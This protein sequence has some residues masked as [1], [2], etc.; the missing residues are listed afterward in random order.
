MEFE[1]CSK[2]LNYRQDWFTMNRIEWTTYYEKSNELILK[3]R[4][5]P[6]PHC[7]KMPSQRKFIKSKSDDLQ[8]NISG[9]YIYQNSFVTWAITSIV[10]S[11]KW[12]FSHLSFVMIGAH[13]IFSHNNHLILCRSISACLD[14]YVFLNIFSL[15]LL[16]SFLFSISFSRFS[17]LVALQMKSKSIACRNS[18]H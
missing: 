9:L 18:F 2:F 15:I 16:L 8:W 3:M 6:S 12:S 13:L 4:K 10:L 11:T 14:C 5:I 1:S 7:H 17:K